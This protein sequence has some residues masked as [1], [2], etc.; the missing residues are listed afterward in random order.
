MGTAA[1]M[2]VETGEIKAIA[3]LGLKKDGTYA[4][5]YNYALGHA[6][7]ANPD[8]LSNNVINGCHGAWICRHS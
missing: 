7:V 2:E 3:N 5:T 8:Q 4:E 6:A 1:V